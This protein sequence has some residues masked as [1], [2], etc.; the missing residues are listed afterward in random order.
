M[1]IAQ[2]DIKKRKHIG[3]EH[4]ATPAYMWEKQVVMYEILG[5]LVYDKL[6]KP[7]TLLSRAKTRAKN[8]NGN[9]LVVDE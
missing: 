2:K 9:I 1:K 8:M 5:N 4:R 3:H 7:A 6:D